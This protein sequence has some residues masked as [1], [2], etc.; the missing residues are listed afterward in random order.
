MPTGQTI[1]GHRCNSV[2]ISFD[3]TD[4]SLSGGTTATN[5]WL[6]VDADEDGNFTTGPV[7]RSNP[8]R[9]NNL[10]LGIGLSQKNNTMISI[11]DQQ[12]RR[13]LQKEYILE[14]GTNA[15]TIDLTGYATGL[16][17]VRLQAGTEFS[18]LSFLK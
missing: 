13:L 14:Q 7:A 17:F 15:V 4:L 9:G 5:Y 10:Q 1:N 11:T 3:L 18:T 2:K 8:I 12:G 6:L 16:Y